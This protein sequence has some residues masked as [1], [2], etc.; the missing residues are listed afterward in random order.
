MGTRNQLFQSLKSKGK[1][2][3]RQLEYFMYE[4][5]KVVNLEKLNRLPKINKQL[6]SYSNVLPCEKV[7]RFI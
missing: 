2:V 3:D 7:N 1:I 4:Y 5:K 6:L